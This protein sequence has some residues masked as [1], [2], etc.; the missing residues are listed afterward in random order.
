[1][2]TYKPA[3][4][5]LGKSIQVSCFFLLYKSLT[6]TVTLTIGEKMTIHSFI[7]L[8]S[9]ITG[10]LFFQLMMQNVLDELLNNHHIRFMW[11]VNTKHQTPL[12]ILKYALTTH[13]QVDVHQSSPDVS[14]V[15]LRFCVTH[16]NCYRIK[17][18]VQYFKLVLF[19]LS[20]DGLVSE[21]RSPP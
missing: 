6:P 4:T 19:F 11:H 3:L 10:L 1:M 21:H 14:E 12:V 16:L 7:D 5:R 18:D 9:H 17:K 2:E 8:Y 20:T 15:L 13:T